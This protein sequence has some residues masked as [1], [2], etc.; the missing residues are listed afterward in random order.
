M[1]R[2]KKYASDEERLA[3]N[4]KKAREAYAK[5]VGD[6]REYS[7]DPDAEKYRGT[8][9]YRLYHG[10]KTRAKKSGLPFNLTCEYI[11]DLL[12]STDTCPLLGI[13]LETGSKSSLS[14]LDKI[15]PHKGYVLGN[16]QILSYRANTIK[17]SASF[18][19]FEVIYLSW[20]AQLQAP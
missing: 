4:A 8:K 20:K 14:S 18:E 3:A 15:I 1:G 9:A 19:E 16:V 13:E 2:P 6:V 17:N 7:K 10:A 12:E 5:K 11:A